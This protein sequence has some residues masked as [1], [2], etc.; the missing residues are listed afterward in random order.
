MSN[1]ICVPFAFKEGFNSGV[2]LKANNVIEIY[3]KNAVVA[4]LSA[5][6]K[7]PDCDVIFATN[8]DAKEIPVEYAKKLMDNGVEIIKV[9]YDTY[10]FDPDYLWSLAFYKLCVL[11]ALIARGFDCCCYLDTDVY[12]QS[13][14]GSIWRECKYKIL[15]YDVNHGL[16]V[17]EYQKISSEIDDFVGKEILA[18]HY[19]G[20]FFAANYENAVTFEQ[21]LAVVYEEMIQREYRTSKGDEFLISIAAERCKAIIKNASPYINRYWTG[22]SFRLVSSNF[23]YNPVTILHLPAEK[24]KGII[25]LYDHYFSK[26]RMPR[27]ETVWRICRLNWINPMKVFLANFIKYIKSH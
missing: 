15:L 12:I 18:T 9:E 20:E 17:V 16:G 8:I 26:N 27:K 14:F 11:K 13:D 19:G 1:I 23:K 25:A 21:E 22:A 4:L 24:E 6:W 3:L 5:K 10:K 2:N 7:N